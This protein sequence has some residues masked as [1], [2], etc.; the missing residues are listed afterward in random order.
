[1]SIVILALNISPFLLVVPIF[2]FPTKAQN[3]LASRPR[4][5]SVEV[6]RSCFLFHT[7]Y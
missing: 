5:E 1:M 4:Y 3:L 6:I 7:K 2:H